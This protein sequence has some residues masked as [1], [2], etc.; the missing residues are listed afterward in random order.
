MSLREPLPE[1]FVSGYS[2]LRATTMAVELDAEP[3]GC[4]MPPHVNEGREKREARYLVVCFS[5][6]VN[7]G[8]TW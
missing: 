8:E 6:R 4:D 1:V 5:M 2:V 3:P 7:A